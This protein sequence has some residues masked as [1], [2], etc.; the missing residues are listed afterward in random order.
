[1]DSA[2]ITSFTA[3]PSFTAVSSFAASSSFTAMP[4]TNGT[5]TP[6]A[7]DAQA[8]K[9]VKIGVALG[10]VGL[11]L[12]TILPGIVLQLLARRQQKREERRNAAL[13][14]CY[15]ALQQLTCTRKARMLFAESALNHSPSLQATLELQLLLSTLSTQHPLPSHI[16]EAFI[17]SIWQ[18]LKPPFYSAIMASL[19]TTASPAST[20]G[21]D[22][23]QTQ[24][25]SLK[26]A[27]FSMMGAFCILG[28][29]LCAWYFYK[30]VRP[31]RLRMEERDRIRAAEREERHRIAEMRRARRGEADQDYPPAIRN[32]GRL[33]VPTARESAAQ[34]NLG[35]TDTFI[36]APDVQIMV[37]PPSDD[38]VDLEANRIRRTTSQDEPQVTRTAIRMSVDSTGPW[39]SSLMTLLGLKTQQSKDVEL[40][41]VV[42]PAQ[43][44]DLQVHSVEIPGTNY[45]VAPDGMNIHP[46]GTTSVADDIVPAT[47]EQVDPA[48]P[49]NM[50]IEHIQGATSSGDITMYFTDD[51]VCETPDM[52]PS[53]PDRVAATPDM[54]PAT[55]TDIVP[56]TP[57]MVPS[58]PDNVVPARIDDMVPET[59]RQEDEV[60]AT[61]DVNLSPAAESSS[62]QT[63]DDIEST[64]SSIMGQSGHTAENDME[65]DPIEDTQD[66]NTAG[67][68]DTESLPGEKPVFKGKV[69]VVR[70][71]RPQDAYCSGALT[72]DK[73]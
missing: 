69:W 30:V 57:D 19:T 10:I 16:H 60:P 37:S 2:L 54:T 63:Q 55:P 31:N 66:T 47:Q 22:P 49:D 9:V 17:H 7:A 23:P 71:A 24:S 20:S 40:Q 43:Q 34:R 62:P 38:G 5:T 8:A 56:G 4:Q 70:G 59:Q 36:R 29:G 14:R 51:R 50:D 68:G 32:S 11:F 21:I 1:M 26:I 39:K 25:P 58:T 18:S 44:S 61:P 42:I 64:T 13:L 27:F 33:E 12:L 41:S 3:S 46:Q 45:P 48:T 15:V 28:P 53:T 6:T 35:R 73:D 67:K 52:I 72:D 65:V